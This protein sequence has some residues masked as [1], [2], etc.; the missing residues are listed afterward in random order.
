MSKPDVQASKKTHTIGHQHQQCATVLKQAAQEVEQHTGMLQVFEHVETQNRIETGI[1][2][3]SESGCSG[4]KRRTI[5]CGVRKNRLL[6]ACRCKAS[7]S[8]AT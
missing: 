1:Q 8:A 5:T 4:S 7:F 3:A 6:S 2:V